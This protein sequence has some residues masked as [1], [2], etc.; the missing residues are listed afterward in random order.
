MLKSIIRRVG[1]KKSYYDNLEETEER[2]RK[3]L[4]I[5]V[6]NVFGDYIDYKDINFSVD[7]SGSS[8]TIVA[9]SKTIANEIKLS[10]VELVEA[11]RGEGLVIKTIIVQ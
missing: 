9:P 1:I 4:N 8:L 6:V 2:I 5:Y 11:L 7:I 10:L 3:A